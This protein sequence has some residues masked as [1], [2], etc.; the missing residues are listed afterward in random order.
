MNHASL[1]EGLSPFRFMLQPPWLPQSWDWSTVAGV[2]ALNEEA[3]RQA[4]TIAYLND[5]V[6]MMWLT[7]LSAP[8]LLLLRVARHGEPVA[9][10]P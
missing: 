9:H 10:A 3:T 7:L 2:I 6:F 4:S 8:L 5:F 1:V